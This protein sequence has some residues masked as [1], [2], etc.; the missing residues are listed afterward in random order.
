MGSPYYGF[1]IIEVDNAE[2][3]A[4]GTKTLVDR[5]RQPW[6]PVPLEPYS[7]A[8]H[9]KTH[10]Y[11]FR[12]RVL[13][14]E[15]EAKRWL[16]REQRGADGS[17]RLDKAPEPPVELSAVRDAIEA[18][19]PGLAEDFACTWVQVNDTRDKDELRAHVDKP[20]WG[21]IV[22]V[23]TLDEVEVE[24]SSRD[25][26]P[27]RVVVPSGAANGRFTVTSTP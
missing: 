16:L 3:L 17:T 22:I 26:P 19:L 2:A 1:E 12:P 25:A 23:F 27:M 14:D 20:A 9:G 4:A 6:G 8:E 21:D 11:Q 15:D 18:K 10:M 5:L 13:D 24:L 7:Q